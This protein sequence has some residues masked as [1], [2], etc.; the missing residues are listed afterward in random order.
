MFSPTHRGRA[1]DY[2]LYSSVLLIVA[3]CGAG[4]PA[5]PVAAPEP[6]AAPLAVTSARKPAPQIRRRA[7]KPASQPNKTVRTTVPVRLD[8]TALE[9][10]V[11]REHAYWPLAIALAR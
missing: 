7:E 5:L 8:S 10:N 2:C 3:A 6:A 4:A 9:R 11:T 1:L